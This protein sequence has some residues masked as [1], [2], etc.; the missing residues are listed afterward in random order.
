MYVVFAK[1]KKTQTNTCSF[2]VRSPTQFG[3]TFNPGFRI[4]V[5]RVIQ[6]QMKKNS[7]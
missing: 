5:L 3:Q 6:S 4:L 1:K 7:G 2:S